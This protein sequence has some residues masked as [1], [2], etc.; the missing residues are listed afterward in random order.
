MNSKP[1]SI[2]TPGSQAPAPSGSPVPLSR[3]QWLLAGVAIGLLNVLITNVHLADRPIGASTGYPY[4]AGLVAGLEG[5]EYFRQIATAGS[6]ELLFLAG[7]FCGALA[8]ALASRTFRLRGVPAL[9]VRRRGPG[10]VR[11]L[12]WAFVG[13]FLLILGARLAGGC[14]SGHIL[15]GGMELA[16]SGLLFA[17]VVVACFVAASRAFY[18][19]SR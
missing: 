11:R 8:G 5:A 9:W 13:G 2:V 10:L 6:W 14:T 15:S 17:L 4:L 1:R 7:G 18:G 12:L 3:R 19:V 16:A